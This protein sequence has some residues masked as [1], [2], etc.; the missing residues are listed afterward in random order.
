M[1]VAFVALLAGL[2]GTAVALPGK[3]TV[4]S[5]D[6][7]RGAVR[8]S[9][10][11]NGAVKSADIKNNSVRGRDIRS[12]TVT[13][14]DIAESSLGK[15]PSAATAD[16]AAN[17]TNAT[18]ATTAGFA[19]AAGTAGPLAYARVEQDG[20]V[21]GNPGLAKNI[22]DANI[23]NPATGVYCFDLSFTPTSVLVTNETNSDND[24]VVS[25]VVEA[26][27][28]GLINCPAGSEVEVT[29]FDAGT[30]ANEDGDF[31][32]QLNR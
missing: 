25:A 30:P 20:T 14:S 9:D 31:Y 4:D 10:I 32:I 8:T 21:S 5:G 1:T 28:D 24:E 17:A 23:T 27:S 22:S 7:K 6:I 19:T 16:T 12:N 11:K 29:V 26:S 18:K 2:S 13:G 15:V 3:N